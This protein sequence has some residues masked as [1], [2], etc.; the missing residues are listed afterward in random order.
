MKYSLGFIVIMLSILC[1]S[2]KSYQITNESLVEQLKAN[3][4]IAPN[5]YYRQFSL[6]NYPSN[7]LTK[8][9]CID[10]LGNCVWLYPDKNTSFKLVRKSTR[11]SVTL[12]FDTVILQNDTLSG[13]KSRLVG[14][15]RVFPLSDLEKVIIQAEFPRTELCQ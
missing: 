15:Q 14:M 13:L 6:V 5:A 8:I 4:T 3:Q 9:K 11:K 1:T 2:C 10:R 7:N 12:Y